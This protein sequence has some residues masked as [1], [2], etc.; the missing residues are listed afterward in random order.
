LLTAFIRLLGKGG[1]EPDK[2]LPGH[3]R[4]LAFQQFEKDFHRRWDDLPLIYALICRL[5]P[6]A[7]ATRLPLHAAERT[8]LSVL[9]RE[10]VP[11]WAYDT[12]HDYV[13]DLAR[14][15][16]QRG[17]SVHDRDAYDDTPL[18]NWCF[19]PDTTSAKGL[20]MLL[21]A[22]ADLDATAIY[23]LCI[24]GRIQVLRELSIAGR[25]QVTDL[26]TPLQ[27]FRRTLNREFPK[28]YTLST[29]MVFQLLWSE[30]RHW[31][32]H[33]RVAVLA[34]LSSHDSLVPDLAELIVSF[35]DGGRKFTT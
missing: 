14:A 28:S 5:P 8:A 35:I 7:A 30:Q 11:T 17:A 29:Q 15:L 21:D 33:V 23:Y 13:L 6:L 20:L 2:S 4:V 22:G 10:F 26:D 16:L 3:E 34:L 18:R 19:R 9:T 32:G 31:H 24:R 1:D 27:R 12:D 25:L